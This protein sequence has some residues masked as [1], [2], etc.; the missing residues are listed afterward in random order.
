MFGRSS[1]Q[2]KQRCRNL[3]SPPIPVRSMLQTNLL[4][5]R[6][7]RTAEVAAHGKPA[8]VERGRTASTD[9]TGSWHGSIAAQ[10][11]RI[12]IRGFLRNHC[13]QPCRLFN[14]REGIPRRL[15]ADGLPLSL[16]SQQLSSSSSGRRELIAI[17]ETKKS[18]LTAIAEGRGHMSLE[19]DKLERAFSCP[20][21]DPAFH[22]AKRLSHVCHR[23]V[24][25]LTTVA[26]L[27][28]PSSIG[29]Q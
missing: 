18:R 12:A 24:F 21:V 4:C 13:L 19:N 20:P 5:V 11:P 1:T 3:N 2:T 23:Q 27:A 8:F 29:G 25:W 17:P 15:R 22:I 9:V 7:P 28:F 10:S 6:L 26:G 14:C 16:C